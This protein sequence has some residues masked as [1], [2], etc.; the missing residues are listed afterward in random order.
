MRAREPN[1]RRGAGSAEDHFETVLCG[2]GDVL[3]EPVE[4]VTALFRFH[5]VPGELAHVDELHAEFA[6]V[7]HVARPLILRPRFGV[8][9][10]ADAEHVTLREPIRILRVENR[11]E[12]YTKQ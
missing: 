7:R 8:V 9:I 5:E 6:D 10:D 12:H 3:F 1:G 4:L 11:R 2:E